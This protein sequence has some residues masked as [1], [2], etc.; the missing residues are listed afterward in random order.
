M[1]TPRRPFECP[2]SRPSAVLLLVAA[3][4]ALLLT[5]GTADARSRPLSGTHSASAPATRGP[6]GDGAR[7]RVALIGVPGLE[8]SDV[9][10]VRTPNLWRLVGQ[11]A[12]ASLSTRAVPPPDRGITCPAAGWL[13][14]SA[15][16]RA[17]T[18]G[19]GC[20]APPTPQPDGEG[21]TVPGWP[22]LTA[23]QSETGYAARLGTLGQLV[24]DSGGKVAAIGPGAAIAGADKSGN[25]AKYASTPEALGDPAPYN[26]IV[27]EAPALATAWTRQPLDEY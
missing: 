13:T 22:A 15:G 18:A 5:P 20:P 1:P 12:S 9:D 10:Q 24:T 7:G 21:A 14:V 17:G 27:L 8:W 23:Y 6:E 2:A 26:L 25:I 3:L 4:T 11:G 19:K 16:Q